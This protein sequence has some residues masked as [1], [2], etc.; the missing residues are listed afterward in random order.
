MQ[1]KEWNPQL[2]TR[3]KL[4]IGEKLAIVVRK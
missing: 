1:I 4:Y 3:D 2:G